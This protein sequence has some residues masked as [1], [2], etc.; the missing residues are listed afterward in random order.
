MVKVWHSPGMLSIHLGC[1]F[2]TKPHLAMWQPLAC[3]V[4]LLLPWTPLP[5]PQIHSLAPLTMRLRST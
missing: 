5:E 2:S 4:L 1:V 3:Q